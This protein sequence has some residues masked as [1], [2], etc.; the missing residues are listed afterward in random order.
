MS[1]DDSR[2]K[3]SRIVDPLIEDLLALSDEELIAEVIA[4]GGDPAVL[5]AEVGGEIAAAM[6]AH[7]KRKLA[8]ARDELG[9]VRALRNRP[10][11]TALPATEK[12]KILQAFAANDGPL[13]NRLTMAARHGDGLS[14]QE[15]DTVLLDLVELGALDDEGNIR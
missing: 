1:A 6:A 15:V 12:Q 5:A 10:A 8:A 3:L 7:G 2:R 13:K 14:E 11:I 4:D 9:A